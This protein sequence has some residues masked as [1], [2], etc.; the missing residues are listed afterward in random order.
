MIDGLIDLAQYKS[1]QITASQSANTCVCVRVF[2]ST[3]SAVFSDLAA[4]L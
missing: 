3:S 4:N 1:L 2:F